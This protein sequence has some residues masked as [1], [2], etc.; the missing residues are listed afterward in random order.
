MDGRERGVEEGRG[1]FGL[2]VLGRYGWDCAM[3]DYGF[4]H[5]YAF[6]MFLLSCT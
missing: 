6:L 4:G 3:W 5:A 1:L 2:Y